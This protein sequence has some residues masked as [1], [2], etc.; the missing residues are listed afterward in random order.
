M[1]D[2]LHQVVDE[3]LGDAGMIT[4]IEYSNR[5]AAYVGETVTAG[6]TVMDYDEAIGQ[7]TLE[8]FVKN[9]SDEVLTPGVITAQL[10][11]VS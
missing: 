11:V 5:I 10:T 9:A 4:G 8:V 3:W 1:G 6:G 7:V 2:W